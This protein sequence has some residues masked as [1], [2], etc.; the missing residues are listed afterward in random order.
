MGKLYGV[1]VEEIAAKNVNVLKGLSV[2]Q[3]IKIPFKEKTEIVKLFP[4]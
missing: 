2:G 3:Q 4:M 1:S